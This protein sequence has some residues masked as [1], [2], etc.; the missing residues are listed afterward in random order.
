MGFVRF[1]LQRRYTFFV[2]GIVVVLGGIAA[3]KRTPTDVFPVI[4]IPV[5]TIVWFYDGLTGDE[6]EKRIT[7]YSEFSL[8]FFVDNIRNIESQTLPG[9]VVEKVYF[10]PT[11]KVEMAMS[12]IVS[13]T[14]SIRAVL[15]V[16]IQPPIIMQFTASS[17]PVLR[18]S[19]SSDALSDTQLY[20]Y[21][22]YRVRQQL[23]PIQGVT[24][25]SPYGG[26]GRQ[27]MVDLD[28]DALV[29]RGITPTDVMTAMNKQSLSLEVDPENWTTC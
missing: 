2:L 20:D 29:A 22:V 28:P 5:I 13:A 19:L 18:L 23:A 26:K 24:L 25:P 16:G 12:Q 3:I 27:I 15:P 6:T 7:T 14:S 8:S 9:L 10:Q 11:A 4:D 1:A 21:G 17:V